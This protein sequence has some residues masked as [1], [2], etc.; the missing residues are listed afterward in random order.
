MLPFI[1]H[2][3][4]LLSSQPCK[5]DIIIPTLPVRKLWQRKVKGLGFLVEPSA[6]SAHYPP[7][8]GWTKGANDN[9]TS[10]QSLK[11]V[12]FSPQRKLQPDGLDLI[13]H[14]FTQENRSPNKP[15]CW[16]W[17]RWPKLVLCLWRCLTVLVDLELTEILNRCSIF[18]FISYEVKCWKNP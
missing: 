1:E 15:S 13:L 17:M 16:I 4:E 6:F 18:A 2:F 9:H 5:A 10:P 14:W 8:P 11:V 12:S 7:L 3:R